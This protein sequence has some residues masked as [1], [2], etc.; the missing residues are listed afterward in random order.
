MRLLCWLGLL[1]ATTAHGYPRVA[2]YANFRSDGWPVIV[3]GRV[4]TVTAR[5]IA[6]FPLVTVDLNTALLHPEVPSTLR[7]FNPA[8]RPIGYHLVTHW[9]L[10][11]T[12]TP[13]PGDESFNAL[14][15]RAIVAA[16][17][18]ISGAPSGY[19]VDWS[20]SA[21]ADTLAG[22]VA[23]GLRASGLDGMFLDYLEPNVA[24]AGIGTA[25]TDSLR[26]AH[27]RGLVW[28]TRDAL[29]CGLPV[30]GNTYED[31]LPLDGV[32][33][34]GFP[35]RLT[36]FQQAMDL[37]P[38]DWLKGEWYADWR[39][40]DACRAARFVT[41]TA[42]L[43]GAWAAFGTD[44][45]PS[46]EGTWWYDEWSVTPVRGAWG[47]LSDTTGAYTDWLGEPAAPAYR[48]GGVWRRDFEH[49]LV[50]VNETDAPVTVDLIAPRWRRIKGK[51]DPWT[52]NGRQERYVTVGAR[53]ALFLLS[54]PTERGER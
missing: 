50:L 10:G 7:W 13:R 43:T 6:R 40:R 12:F 41:G 48:F 34:E 16:D 54:V 8:C 35:D 52:N 36:S 28:R 46:L 20:D 4:D 17:G 3:N 37:K 32:M 38:G 29:G 5:R 9:W 25:A 14:W 15:H 42:C 24:W 22:L 31:T 19:E 26:L 18:F 27:M 49:G 21:M 23:R 1:L 39:T 33:R 30:Y 2:S 45:S 47:G 44:R 51:L 53:D 11:P